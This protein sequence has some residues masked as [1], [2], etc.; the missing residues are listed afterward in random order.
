M[1]RKRLCFW[2]VLMLALAPATALWAKTLKVASFTADV[3]AITSLDTSFDPDS[4]II[5]TQIFDSLVHID[6]DGKRTPALATS[7]TLVDDTTYEFELR[8]GVK[9][10]N[11]EE[12]DAQAVKYTYETIVDP[13]TKA[14]NAWIMNT[15]KE[16]E[17]I[18]PFKV[19]IKLTHPD[20][21]F[22]Y[23][24]NLFGS[25]APPKYIREVGLDG[26]NKKPV[27]TGPFK[28]V[29]WDKGK[30]IVLAKNPGYWKEGVPNYDELVFKILPQDKWADAL[31]AGDVDLITDVPPGD[32]SKTEANTNLKTMHR[33]VLQSYWVLLKN[34]GPLADVRVRQALNYAVNK[35]RLIKAQGGGHGAAMASL[36]MQK[37]VGQNTELAP[38]AYDPEKAKSLLAEAGYSNG[39]TLKAISISEAGP[40][41][42]TIREDLSK[43]GVNVDLEAVSR[44]E[45]AKKVIVGKMQG[46]PYPGDMAI[47]LVDNPIVDMAFHAGLFLAS[48]SPWSFLNDPEFDKKFQWAL[49][50]ASPDKHVPALRTLD[51]YIHDQALMLFTFQTDRYFAM[52]KDVTVSNVGLNGHIDYVVFSEAK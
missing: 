52:K 51:Q 43:V 18:D 5:I 2:L 41:N 1:I 46:T 29:S 17:I 25:I 15:I 48:P 8:K 38:Y 34:Q 35:D 39:F 32:I 7:W 10:H 44:P 37:E 6:L 14:G 45:W 26:F 9:F 20:G 3:P 50:M 13:K 21:L 24:L 11:G 33:L 19:R 27:G 42:A 4:Y 47:N 30:E 16:V 36:G 22:L 23:R 31:V 28:F 40:L 12:F 49:F